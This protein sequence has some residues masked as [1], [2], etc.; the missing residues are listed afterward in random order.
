MAESTIATFE[1]DDET[2]ISSFQAFPKADHCRQGIR[3]EVLNSPF[4]Y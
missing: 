3:I 4:T 2:R 1:S